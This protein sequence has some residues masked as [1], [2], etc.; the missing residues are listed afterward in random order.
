[1]TG[2]GDTEMVR[3]KQEMEALANEVQNGKFFRN[4]YVHMCMVDTNKNMYTYNVGNVSEFDWQKIK[5]IE[6]QEMLNSKNSLLKRLRIEF[7]CAKCP[8]LNDHVIIIY[9]FNFN[10]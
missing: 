1:M 7:Q 4:T 2:K 10:H 5:D 3:A 8:D 6:F 9:I